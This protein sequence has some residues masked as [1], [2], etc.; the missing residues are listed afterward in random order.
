MSGSPKKKRAAIALLSL[1][2]CSL[3]YLLQIGSI[4]KEIYALSL[5]PMSDATQ[6][7][8]LGEPVL[9]KGSPSTDDSNGTKRAEF[10]TFI[11]IPKTGR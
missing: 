7:S 9:A 3:Y 2:I 11:R 6:P 10:M 5:P 4:L 1:S 8:D